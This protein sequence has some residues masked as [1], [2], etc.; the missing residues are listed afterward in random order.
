MASTYSDLKIQLM[1]TGENSGTWGTVTNTNLGTAI[2]EAITG[3]ADVTFSSADVT[4]T[5]TNTNETQTARN[6]RLNLTGTSGGNRNLIVPAIEK[7]YIINN[8][9]ANQVTVKNATGTGVVVPTGKTMY[10]YNNGTNVVDAI[11]HLTSLTTGTLTSTS[12]TVLNGTTIPASKTLVDTDSAQTLTNK[13]ITSPTID[14]GTANGVT[15]LNG[16]KV[17]TSG[18]ALTFDGSTVT[19]TNTSTFTPLATFVQTAS[20]GG[21]SHI[22]VQS[23]TA[24]I[25]LMSGG[26]SFATNYMGA[27]EAGLVTQAAD[28][29]RFN[30][31]GSYARWTFLSSEQM[32]L[33]STGLGIGTSS[34]SVKL[35]VLSTGSPAQFSSSN[36][37]NTLIQHTNTNASKDLI[38]RFRQNAGSGNWYDLTME[39]A[40]NNFTIDY[41]DT[42][43]LTLDSS[44]NLGLGVTP[45]AWALPA[46]ES[47]YGLWA[48]RVEGNVTSNAYFNGGYKYIASGIESTRY[49][50]LTGTHAW[51]NAPSGTAGNPITFT[52]AMT[53]DAN[54][55]LGIGTSSPSTTLSVAGTAPVITIAPSSGTASSTITLSN[56]SQ[57]W[58][59]ENQYVGG[60]SVGMFRLRDATAGTDVLTVNP[61]STAVTLHRNTAVT[62]TLSITDNLVIGTAG[63]GIDFSADGQA[64]GMTSELLDDYE[65]GTWTPDTSYA[66]FVGAPSSEGTYTKIGRTVVVRGSVTGGTS[67]AVGATGILVGG[68]PFTPASDSIG[69][70]AASTTTE[71]G[72]IRATGPFLV[73]TNNMTPTPSITFTATYFV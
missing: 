5:L 34:P 72:G 27:D 21:V 9:L 6:L 61:S 50:Q 24:Q 36:A 56:P 70:M 53:L 2:E 22:K 54:G 39:G 60:A 66:T 46:V 37:S 26:S 28:G 45:S 35:D 63:K 67:V 40:T 31:G 15:Y 51:Y 62:G 55:N 25:D 52:Q 71:S 4:L 7:V 42:T 17:L 44:G 64:A 18:S 69:I 73:A 38:Y 1:A 49:R 47:Q 19:A 48:G 8:G 16:S 11:T 20:T 58:Q 43:R 32:R 41:N 10:V 14:S 59:L 30:I 23:N 68:L 33:T 12:T 65:E 13:T 29:M 57:S 3:S